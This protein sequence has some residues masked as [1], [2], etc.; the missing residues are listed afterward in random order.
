[1]T[2]WATGWYG[3]SPLARPPVVTLV[4]VSLNPL[5]LNVG[6]TRHAY[7]LEIDDLFT[8]GSR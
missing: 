7:L 5:E 4:I 8:Q 3:L 2:A 1:M 6:V